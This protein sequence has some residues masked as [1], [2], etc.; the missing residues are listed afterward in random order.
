[1]EV[2]LLMESITGLIDEVENLSPRGKKL[3]DSIFRI[4]R[5]AGQLRVPPSF[6]GKVREYYGEKEEDE[7]HTI[8]RIRAQ[9]IVNTFNS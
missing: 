5:Y 4:C 7:R 8:E 9:T 6:R 1:M 2:S 3:F